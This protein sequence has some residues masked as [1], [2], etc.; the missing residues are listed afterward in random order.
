MPT[1]GGSAS[2]CNPPGAVEPTVP[3]MKSPL[4]GDMG[5]DFVP[6]PRDFVPGEVIW[7][8]KF[9]GQTNLSNEMHDACQM[10]IQKV[11]VRIVFRCCS[12]G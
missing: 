6:A 7:P 4:P 2:P 3:W 11:N 10:F 5:P 1:F 9:F 8:G 12:F